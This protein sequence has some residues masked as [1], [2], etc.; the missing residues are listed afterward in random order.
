MF[1]RKV[2]I[3][4]SNLRGHPS[5][6]LFCFVLCFDSIHRKHQV[7]SGMGRLLFH[8]IVPCRLMCRKQAKFI[9]AS[10]FCFCFLADDLASFLVQQPLR[11]MPPFHRPMQ[12]FRLV[13]FA[14]L[15]LVLMCVAEDQEIETEQKL[16]VLNMV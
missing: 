7:K 8:T 2:F 4:E 5:I 15:V 9:G 1:E 13:S 10:P 14:E 6:V 11:S 16:L 3:L 12:S